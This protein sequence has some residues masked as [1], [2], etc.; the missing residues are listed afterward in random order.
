MHKERDEDY[1]WARK[2]ERNEFEAARRV[3]LIDEEAC[4]LRVIIVVSGPSRSRIAEAES[5]NTDG[6]VTAEDTTDGVPTT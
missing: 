2:K 5:S 1:P 6:A 4:K 3:S